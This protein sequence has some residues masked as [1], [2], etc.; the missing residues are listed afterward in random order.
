MLPSLRHAVGT[1]KFLLGNIIRR[2]SSDTPLFM[3]CLDG[4][5]AEHFLHISSDTPSDY[6]ADIADVKYWGQQGKVVVAKGWPGFSFLDAF[7]QT[8]S[9]SLLYSIARTNIH[10]PLAAYLCGAQ[11][12][13][14]FSYSW[15]Y[16]FINT[17]NDCGWF[18]YYQDLFRRLGPPV[19]NYVQSGFLFTRQFAN[20][21]IS[22]DVSNRVGQIIWNSPLVE[23]LN[24]TNGAAVMQNSSQSVPAAVNAQDASGIRQVNYWVNDVLVASNNVAPYS[25]TLPT[26][27]SRD[28]NWRPKRSIATGWTAP[29]WR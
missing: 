28:S 5:M 22:A 16:S 14:Y 6:M 19:T 15:G 13:S 7:A 2:G 17:T 12:N 9:E 25:V 4:A 23:I 21:S 27:P 20:A 10:F 18:S 29:R 3:P 26:C 11:T 8:N 24:P 1:N